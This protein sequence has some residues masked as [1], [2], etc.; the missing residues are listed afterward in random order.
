ALRRR[1][2]MIFQHFNLLSSRTVAGNVAFPL[3]LAGTPKTEI[4]ARVAELLQ[5][6]GL[7]AHAQK[8]PAQLSGGE[9]QRVAV[10]RAF[11][12]SPTL[13]FADEPTSALDAE[14]GQ[15]VI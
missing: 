10:A 5:T 3:E 1:I 7:E 4:D 11:A 2:G 14:N 6:V 9:K 12:K 15:R 8:Y 13:I